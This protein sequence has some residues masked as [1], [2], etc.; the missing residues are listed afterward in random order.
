M[1]AP[2]GK[3]EVTALVCYSRRVVGAVAWNALSNGIMARM[4]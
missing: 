1:P 4:Q 3:T 2:L